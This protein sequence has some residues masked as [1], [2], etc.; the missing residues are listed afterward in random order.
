MLYQDAR[1]AINYASFTAP[2][3]VGYAPGKGW[4]TYDPKNGCPG[5]EPEFFIAKLGTRPIPLSEQ[6]AE[7]WMSCLKS[8]AG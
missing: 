1:E 2:A 6:A 7:V 4:F 8:L 3:C 5:G